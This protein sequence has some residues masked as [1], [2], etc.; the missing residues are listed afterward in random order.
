MTA[1]QQQTGGAATTGATRLGYLHTTVPEQVYASRP[2]GELAVCDL[3]ITVTNHT[4][5]PVYCP[6][7]TIRLPVGAGAAQFAR[8]GAG[9]TAQAIPATWTVTAVQDDVLIAVPD[10]GAARFEPSPFGSARAPTPS[11]VVELRGIRVNRDPGTTVVHVDELAGTAPAGPWSAASHTISIVKR[12]PHS[13]PGDE[14]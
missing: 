6:Q 4:P 10:S 11:L 9:I 14:S 1:P 13:A 7:L 5:G 2:D 3:R 12:A 8:F